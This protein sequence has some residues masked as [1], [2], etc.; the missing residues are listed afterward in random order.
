MQARRVAAG[1]RPDHSDTECEAEQKS[2]EMDP[3]L[4]E[5][6]LQGS[7]HKYYVEILKEL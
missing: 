6:N 2:F 7:H 5:E 4:P 1:I 3:P